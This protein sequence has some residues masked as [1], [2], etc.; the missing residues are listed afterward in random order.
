MGT[1]R[2]NRSRAEDKRAD[3]TR[4][5]ASCTRP[6]SSPAA[7]GTRLAEAA[8]LALLEPGVRSPAGAQQAAGAGPRAP[9]PLPEAV[10]E[11]AAPL[12]RE[13][14]QQESRAASAEDI[15]AAPRPPADAVPAPR[16]RGLRPPRG[17]A[18]CGASSFAALPPSCSP[19][20]SKLPIIIVFTEEGGF[21]LV[22]V[23]GR[24]SVCR[25]P[26][27]GS[28]LSS[29]GEGNTRPCT[30]ARSGPCSGGSSGGRTDRHRLPRPICR[31]R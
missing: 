22:G 11:R 14:S 1:R 17:G 9:V 31:G 8:G 19:G 23:R 3:T 29:K 10:P 26:V 7:A 4:T 20:Y 27:R 24:G 12:E 2:R 25:P 18:F 15:P 6:R 13:E 5:A 30:S 16:H 28:S 21:P